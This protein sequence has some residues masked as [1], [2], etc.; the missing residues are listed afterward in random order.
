MRTFPITL[1]VTALASALLLTGCGS[2]GDGGGSGEKNTGSGS[3]NAG[4]AACRL[5]DIGLRVGPANAA[6]VAGDTGNV[7]VTLTNR[8]STCT[9][10]GFPGVRLTAG[11]T[12]VSVPSEKGAQPQK[13]TLPENGTASFTLTYVRGGASGAGSLA[14]RTLT[15]SLPGSGAHQSHPWSYGPVALKSGGTPDATVSAF[16]QAGD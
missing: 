6:P 9:L 15:I 7:P 5:S 4:A 8:G 13:L 16:Q 1:T 3:K 2:G 10:Q 11:S 12:S 14:A